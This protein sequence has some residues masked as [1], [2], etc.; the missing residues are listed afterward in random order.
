MRL[1]LCK[2]C[3]HFHVSLEFHSALT[4]SDR[5][6][7]DAPRA[8]SRSALVCAA[9]VNL[10][11]I[12]R[13]HTAIV[14]AAT[15]RTVQ[16]DTSPEQQW[17][18]ASQGRAHAHLSFPQWRAG[19]CRLPV[20]ADVEVASL[21]QSVDF[22]LLQGQIHNRTREGDHDVVA[23][24]W[25]PPGTMGLGWKTTHLGNRQHPSQVLSSISRGGALSGDFSSWNKYAKA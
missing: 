12:Q 2:A 16:E 21:G 15:Y 25:N 10:S 18:L 6:D 14:G 17:S 9:S 19:I 3:W 7:V 8:V 5:V 11:T 13:D 20:V 1:L 22:G 24:H 23:E 4:A